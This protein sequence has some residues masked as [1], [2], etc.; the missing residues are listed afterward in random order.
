M[1]W[2]CMKMRSR[3]V[4]VRLG[5]LARKIGGGSLMTVDSCGCV[6]SR[7]SSSN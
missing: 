1:V 4:V 2:R 6:D 5:D 3:S 7:S